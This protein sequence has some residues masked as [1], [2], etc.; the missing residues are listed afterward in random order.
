MRLID[1]DELYDKAEEKY[2]DSSGFYRPIYRGFVDDVASAPTVDAA[3][4]VHGRWDTV[5]YERHST[6]ASYSHICPK[7]KYFYR[8]TKFKGHD[9]CPGCGAK[10]D[11]G[12]EDG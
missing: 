11:G 10:M 1:A 6:I 4:V 9:Y 8:D 2:K 7:C 12:N 5:F 3:P